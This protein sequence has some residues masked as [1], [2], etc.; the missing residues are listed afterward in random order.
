MFK[1]GNLEVYG[2]IYKITN[3]V[4]GKCYI[5]QTVQGFNRRYHGNGT[6][7]NMNG[8]ERVFYYHGLNKNGKKTYN[9][10]LYNSI[11]KYGFDAFEV[12]KEFDIAFSQTE[13]D[14][15]EDLWI[16]YYDCTNKGYNIK[17]G[18]NGGSH[19][20]KEC[21]RRM[22]ESQKIRNKRDGNAFKGKH[23]SEEQK[24]K[25]SEQ[26]K[27]RKLS[28]EWRKHLSEGRVNKRKIINLDTKEIFNSVADAGRKYNINSTNICRALRGKIK[29]CR[30]CKWMYYEEYLKLHTNCEAS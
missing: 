5:G 7:K 25:W 14:I 4:N 27:G 18:G 10:H 6:N 1:I 11:K 9:V 30:G 2:V 13:L 24:Q 28:E 3:K 12:N 8:I 21:R 29:T 22:S 19:Y 26:R 17:T 23:H 20:N 16:K 15:K